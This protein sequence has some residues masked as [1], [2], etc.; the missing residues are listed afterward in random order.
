MINIFTATLSLASVPLA[1]ANANIICDGNSLTIGQGGTPYPTQLA[2]LAPFSTNGAAFSNIGVGGQTTPDMAADYDSQVVAL[3][4]AGKQNNIY[5]CWEGINHLYYNATTTQAYEAIRDLCLRARMTGFYVVVGTL[6][7]R[8]NSGTP[9]DFETKRQEVNTLLRSN[10]RTFAGELA[11]FAADA[12]IG[13]AG[14]ELDTTYYTSD[15]VH[16]NTTGY[17]V[18]AAIVKDTLLRL[19]K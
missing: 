6:T 2:G 13:D 18:V 1:L 3:Y 4:N 7:P 19:K 15:K 14:D 11:D 16:L 17:G 12:R 10:W 5:V 9:A 8:S